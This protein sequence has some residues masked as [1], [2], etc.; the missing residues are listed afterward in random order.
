MCDT[1]YTSST[2]GVTQSDPQ[3]GALICIDWDDTL[4]PTSV[5]KIE[6]TRQKVKLAS[7]VITNAL[8]AQLK[9]LTDTVI[10]FVKAMSA[11]GSVC[12]ITNAEPGWV[13]H[14][15][16]K[17]MPAL[18]PHIEKMRVMCAPD[19]FRKA[20]NFESD[21]AALS[22]YH[23]MTMLLGTDMLRKPILV[24]IGDSSAEKDAS[25]RIKR[26]IHTAD[27]IYS[28]PNRVI[29]V[30]MSHFPSITGIINQLNF[31]KCGI[32]FMMRERTSDLHTCVV[33]RDG[34]A[35]SMP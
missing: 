17:Y 7:V 27:L 15:C 29:T 8:A 31:I 14:S 4:L 26:E 10:E 11:V 33:C 20:W 9:V 12:I 1:Q 32:K 2:D 34:I 23:A 21:D 5:I 28:A 6:A 18:V 30:K 16:K 19:I 25:L 13:Q 22:K 3:T 24:S 35:V